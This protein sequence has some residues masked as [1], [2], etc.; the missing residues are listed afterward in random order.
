[1]LF[2]QSLFSLKSVEMDENNIGAELIKER[3][4]ITMNS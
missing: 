1:M 2:T 4:V 3:E